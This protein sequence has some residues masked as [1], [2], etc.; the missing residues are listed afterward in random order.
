MPDRIK[1]MRIIA[2]MNVGG[3]AIQVCGL[4]RQLDASRFDQRLYTGW[5]APDEADFL[6]TQAPDVPALR[7]NGLG[8]AVRPG[9]DL[10]VVK[11]LIEHIREFRPD[12]IHTHTAKA[13]TLGRLAALT[14]RTNARLVHT[15]HGHLLHGYF[16]PAKTRAVIQLE[17][18]LAK[19]TNV[20]V[21]VGEQV[22]DDLLAAGIG[23]AQQYTIIAPGLEFPEPPP[24][25]E[26]RVELGLSP[27]DLV[28]SYIGR[29]TAIKRADRFADAVALLARDNPQRNLRFLVA[30][31]GES[32]A[33]LAARVHNEHLPVT[34]LG[35]RSD[36]S[37]ILAATDIVVLT[38]DNEGTPISLIQAAIAAIPVVASDVGSVKDVVIDE[39]TGLLARPTAEAIA[40]RLQILIDDGDLRLQMGHAARDRASDRYSV[41][42]LA[43]DHSR[44]YERLMGNEGKH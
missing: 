5:C 37:R 6:L 41:T 26:A 9:D 38:S 19:R 24:R 33:A 34:M 42:R 7:V 18:S 31:D 8:R 13:G 35:W 1:V 15:F 36:I 25:A 10:I 12:V 44:V 23:R 4:M 40:D 30:G 43:A 29:L 32:S 27:D 16:S 2:R 11:R 39:I 21:A 3:P 17:R 22:R 20:I 14:A 28:I